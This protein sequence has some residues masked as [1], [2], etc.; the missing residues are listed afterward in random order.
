ME[1][2]AGLNQMKSGQR[3]SLTGPTGKKV[4]VHYEAEQAMGDDNR[5]ARG[6]T[7]GYYHVHGP[8]EDEHKSFRHSPHGPTLMGAKPYAAEQAAKHISSRLDD[9]HPLH[10]RLGME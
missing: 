8:G 5:P 7:V 3:Q 6:Y 1:L 10:G 9:V 4:T 2:S